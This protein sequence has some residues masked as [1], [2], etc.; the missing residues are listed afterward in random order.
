MENTEKIAIRWRKVGGGTFRMANG[1]IIKPNQTFW[2]EINNIPEGFRDTIVPLSE[3]P[4]E[5]PL[6]IADNEYKLDSRG[7]GWYNITD[8]QGKV[9]NENA[10]R[11]DEA[12][13]MLESLTT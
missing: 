9:L 7:A 13:E 5:K 8:S 6:E 12:K 10:L 3:L 2:A 4:E 11:E 1:K